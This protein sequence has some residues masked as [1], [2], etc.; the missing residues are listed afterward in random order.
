MNLSFKPS[1][2]HL[3]VHIY[4][5]AFS[6][7]IGCRQLKMFLFH[8]IG[9]FPHFLPDE[10]VPRIDKGRVSTVQHSIRSVVKTPNPNFACPHSSACF[11]VPVA[12]RI[13]SASSSGHAALSRPAAP[14]QIPTGA[15]SNHRQK[16]S[17]QIA[18]FRRVGASLSWTRWPRQ[19]DQDFK[20]VFRGMNTNII[21]PFPDTPCP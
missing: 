7:W 10:E 18:S 9:Q 4:T 13:E 16:R 14:Y 12:C 21:I 2:S 1:I 6:S 17:Q 20:G 8:P 15:W 5:P 3:S 11:N 19:D